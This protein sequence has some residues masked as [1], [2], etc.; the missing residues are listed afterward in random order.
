MNS[1][2]VI[3]AAIVNG[4]HWME[5]LIN[6]VDF[7]VEKFIIIDNNGKGELTQDLRRLAD[8]S[9]P[10]ISKIHLIEMPSNL[11]VAASWNLLIKT[12]LTAPYWLIASHDIAFTP[13]ILEEFYLNAQD[14]KVGMV[15]GSGGDFGDG[16]YDLFLIKDWVIQKLG[17][18]DENLYPAYC[19]DVDYIMKNTRWRWDYPEDPIKRVAG[20]NTPYYHGNALS[21]DPEYYHGGAQ[22]KKQSAELNARLD[23]I[24]VMN[25]EYMYQKWGPGW[26]MTN[27]WK[28]PLGLEGMPMT[29]TSF[30]LE[31]AR[32]KHLGF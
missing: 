20:L 13:G 29:Y 9:H 25:F 27:P 32:S 1:I 3:G 11:G 28:Y 8:T 30:D 4:F 17:L 12:N 31:F 18:F 7:P 10:F 16:A 26:R 5:R 21:N 22:T 15:H 6:S 24:N 14:P 2:P 23:N 19:E